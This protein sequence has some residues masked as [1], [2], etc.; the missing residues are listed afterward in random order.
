MPQT[1]P[2]LP[3]QLIQWYCLRASSKAHVEC[4][5]QVGS[6]LHNPS[7]LRSAR[8]HDLRSNLPERLLKHCLRLTH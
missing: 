2:A 5:N 6:W 7:P 8:Y 4:R 3:E 1:D